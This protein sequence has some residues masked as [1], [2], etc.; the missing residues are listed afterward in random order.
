MQVNFSLTK[1]RVAKLKADD[2]DAYAKLPD[3]G[4]AEVKV[5]YNTGKNLQEMAQL[6]T[7]KIVRNLFEGHLK[8]TRRGEPPLALV[9]AL[10]RIEF[11]RE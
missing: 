5:E 11:A 2:K 10:D 8:F 7:E 4:T 6:F 1:D 3:G 9:H